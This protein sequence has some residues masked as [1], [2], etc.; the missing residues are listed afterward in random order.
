V[1]DVDER[2]TLL[3]SECSE[4]SAVEQLN[5]MVLNMINSKFIHHNA[6]IRVFRG[7]RRGTAERDGTEHD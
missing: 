3:R 2:M 5:E 6:E 7:I 1:Q 4:E